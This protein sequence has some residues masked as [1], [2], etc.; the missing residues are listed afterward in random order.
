MSGIA[1]H[2]RNRSRP[3][4]RFASPG[5]L[6]GDA[7]SADLARAAA[8]PIVDALLRSLGTAVFVLNEHRQILAANTASL[9]MLGLHDPDGVLGLRPGEAIR[10]VHAREEEGGCGTSQACA[11]CG[12][13]LAVLLARRH[14][15]P[16]ERN[17]AITIP[18]GTGT[19]DIDLRVR[20]VPLRIDGHDLVLVALSDIG[21]QS[22]REAME[23]AFL[24]DIANLLTGLVAAADAIGSPDAEGDDEATADVRL[25]AD[26]LVREVRLQRVLSSNVFEEYQPAHAPVS[27]PRLCEDLARLFNRYPD[28]T[29]RTLEVAPPE[30]RIVHTDPFLLARI[31]TN[32]LKNAFEATPAGGQVRL[33]VRDLDGVTSFEVHN[34]GAIPA[35]VVPRIFQRHFTTKSGPGRGEGSWSVKSLGERFLHGTVGFE[36]DRVAGTTFWFRLPAAPT[37]PAS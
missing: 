22:R 20:A 25:I 36:T 24:H 21:Q 37:D 31:L 28:A 26:R 34:P 30:R 2:G 33:S 7:L 10:C 16:E 11:T 35:A 17:C 6:E 14:D 19:V 8:S 32:L 18:S 5:R 3:A 9:Q 12:A 4:T 15:R 13:V 23:R 29:S 27:I 1:V